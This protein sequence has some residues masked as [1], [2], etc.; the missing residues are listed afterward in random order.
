MLELSEHG[1]FLQ[2]PRRSLNQKRTTYGE[3]DTI[4]W[5]REE[6]A[7]RAR[8]RRLKSHRGVKGLFLPFLDAS[9]MWFVIVVTGIGIGI[10]GAWLD[11]L[12]KW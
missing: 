5:A 1:E 2:Q 8:L 10:V 3:G 7:E 4:D 12:V 11:V 6:G 9:R